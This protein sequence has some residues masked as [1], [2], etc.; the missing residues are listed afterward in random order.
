MQSTFHPVRLRGSLSGVPVRL[1]SWSRNHPQSTSS[2]AGTMPLRRRISP[3]SLQITWS[4]TPECGPE[5]SM[6]RNRSTVFCH[7]L[8]RTTSWTL[9]ACRQRSSPASQTD[10]Y[11]IRRAPRYHERL[12]PYGSTE[13]RSGQS[14]RKFVLRSDSV[15]KLTDHRVLTGYRSGYRSSPSILYIIASISAEGHNAGYDVTAD[16]ERRDAVVKPRLIMKSRA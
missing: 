11:G 5:M 6:E 2:G 8:S 15:D 13:N 3:L 1:L 9:P 14:L 7:N 10:G 16:H 4:S 12:S